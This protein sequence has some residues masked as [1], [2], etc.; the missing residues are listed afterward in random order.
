MRG[1]YSFSGRP[2]T[3]AGDLLELLPVT[4]VNISPRRLD[5]VREAVR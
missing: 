3:A 4:D 1:A 2:L 5:G